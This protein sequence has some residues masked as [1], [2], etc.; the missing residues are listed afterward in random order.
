MKTIAELNTAADN[1]VNATEGENTAARIGGFFRDII[2]HLEARASDTATLTQSISTEST[3]A[4][5]AEQANAQSI[6]NLNTALTQAVVNERQRAQAAETVLDRKI[7]DLGEFTTSAAAES[8]A[9]APSIAGDPDIYFMRYSVPEAEG[10]GV[11]YG[12]IEQHVNVNTT[13]QYLY[14]RTSRYYRVITFTDVTRETVA[15]VASWYALG[16]V[17]PTQMNYLRDLVSN[18]TIANI[19]AELGDRS[20]Y[21][22]GD[23]DTVW[24]TLYAL[25]TDCVDFDTDIRS[26]TAFVGPASNPGSDTLRVRVPALESTVGSSSDAPDPIG[27]T[28]WGLLNSHDDTINDQDSQIRDC[29]TDITR[30]KKNILDLGYVSGS[31]VA[32]NLAAMDTY[33]RNT[34]IMLMIYRVTSGNNAGGCGYIEQ[35]VVSE[36][37]TVQALRWNQNLYRRA[38]TRSGTEGNYTWTAGAW[39]LMWE[40]TKAQYDSILSRLTALEQANAS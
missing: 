6:R 9:A 5:A 12:Y 7:Y 32:E 18:G 16:Y 4:Q 33:C 35:R 3:R 26:L 13:E 38:I 39:T 17:T 21:Q 8:A 15:S 20:Y 2:D 27:N 1:V 31:G 30:L 14:W 22:Y 23:T 25:Q 37:T 36:D 24:G 10:G 40:M 29:Q 28:I 11:R 19:Q 34:D